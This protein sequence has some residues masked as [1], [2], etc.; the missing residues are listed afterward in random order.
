M[1]A[2]NN[3]KKRVLYKKCNEVGKRDSSLESQSTTNVKKSII[4][5]FRLFK[6]KWNAKMQ[7]M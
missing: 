1:G 7:K 3:S 2:N 6:Q 5:S 4:S